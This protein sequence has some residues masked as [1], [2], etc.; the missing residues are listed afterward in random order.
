VKTQGQLGTELRAQPCLFE[1]FYDTPTLRQVR[2]CLNKQLTWHHELERRA[3]AAAGSSAPPAQ[4][5]ED[6]PPAD[7][8]PF[9][10]LVAPPTALDCRSSRW[11]CASAVAR[12]TRTSP[13]AVV[14]QLPSLDRP[15][16]CTPLAAG[17]A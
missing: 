17:A 3:R 7:E 14:W 4:S 16:V 11:R 5:G 13:P 6:R 12:Q 2:R 15:R 9:P 1:P 10:V 8:V